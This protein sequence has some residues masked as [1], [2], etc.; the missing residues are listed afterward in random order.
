[1]APLHLP[2]Q[3]APWR[4]RTLLVIGSTAALILSAL[5][6]VLAKDGDAQL[7]VDHFLGTGVFA[8]VT[9]NSGIGVSNFKN[10]TGL[11]CTTPAQSGP[12]FNTDCEGNAPHNE[13]TIA[14]NPTNPDNMIASAND[15]QLRLTPG[16]YVYESAYSRAHVTTDGGQTWSTYGINYR[17]YVSTGDPIVAFDG[18]GNAYLAT[19]GFLWPQGPGYGINADILVAH[20]TDGGQTWS[21][22]SRVAQGTGSWASVSRASLDKE[23]MVAWGDGNAIVTYTR[24]IQGP[25][26]SYGGSPIMAVVTH[27][28]GKTWSKPVEISGSSADCFNNTCNLDQG[29]SPVVAADGSIYV[30]FMNWTNP[31]GS[32]GRDQYLVVKVDPDTGE[33]VAGP[34]T[35]G[36]IYDGSSDYPLAYD[37]SQ[38]YQDSQFRSWAFGTIAADPT[39]ASHLAVVWSDMRNSTLPAPADPYSTTT[40]SDIIV[41]QSFDGGATWSAPAAVAAP[42]D[43][44]QPW[45]TYDTSGLL[46]MTYFDRSYDPA[47]HAYGYTLA[48]ETS[49]G[50]LAF[51]DTQLTTTLSD[52][53]QGDRWFSGVTVNEA[54][55]HPTT[56]LGDYSWVAASPGGGVVAVWTDMRNSTT[57]CSRTGSA[58]DMYFATA[59]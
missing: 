34:F 54:F 1:M 47:N 55:P 19:L 37:G 2:R 24:F 32:T 26:A 22:P 33:R 31:L 12:N 35:V 41:S 21:T 29:S 44:F 38:T 48:T 13:T 11:I 39:D 10:R 3:A 6:P 50:S 5:T 9:G 52:P 51:S 28:G 57:F 42:G 49:W 14:V 45:A 53:T 20:S 56:F 7:P 23:N 43:Q 25:H 16:G 15:Y 27:D 58:E 8:P 18:S 40:N 46:R 59:P 4:A 17:S 36:D 30:S